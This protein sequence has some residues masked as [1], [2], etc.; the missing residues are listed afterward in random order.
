M[1]LTTNLLES[2]DP[3][4]E[5][6][7]NLRVVFPLPDARVRE[8][9]WRK[10]LDGS[11]LLATGVNFAELAERFPMSGGYIKNAVEK[12]MRKLFYLREKNPGQK[13]DQDL[14]LTC[15]QAEFLERYAFQ[16]RK[17]NCR[18]PHS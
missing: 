14:L 7:L 3:A 17:Q 6:R 16:S 10:F 2:L 12:S 15:A 18:L 5:R 1:A 8:Q 11:D 9:I 4:L 13:L